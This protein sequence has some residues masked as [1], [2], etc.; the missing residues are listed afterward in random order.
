MQSILQLSVLALPM[1]PT[2]LVHFA[3]TVR[4]LGLVT[5]CR[6]CAVEK[7]E[8][9][10]PSWCSQDTATGCFQDQKGALPL[11]HSHPC[12]QTSLKAG[13]H[14]LSTAAWLASLQDSSSCLRRLSL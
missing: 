2:V 4:A 1:T 11:L 9:C 13:F 10:N 3:T 5:A 6:Q 7:Q 8:D 12:C 14:A